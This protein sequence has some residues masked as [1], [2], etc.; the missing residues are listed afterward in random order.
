MICVGTTSQLLKQLFIVCLSS[1]QTIWGKIWWQRTS[2]YI[3]I[4]CPE[5]RWLMCT[6]IALKQGRRFDNVFGL[7]YCFKCKS[8]LDRNYPFW[9]RAWM[10][11][12]HACAKCVQFFCAF[13]QRIWSYHK[14]TRQWQV[15]AF[16]CFS[17]FHIFCF[18]I[19]KPMELLQYERF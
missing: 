19:L 18:N 15:K 13:I 3:Y 9:N 8:N 17:N 2:V 12:I 4:Y 1:W 5:N 16:W 7:L 14:L 6:F 11:A 10:L